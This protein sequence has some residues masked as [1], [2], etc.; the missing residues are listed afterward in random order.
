[1]VYV[2]MLCNIFI[3]NMCTCSMDIF[4]FLF[5]WCGQ[6]AAV[7]YCIYISNCYK[8][9]TEYHNII[10]I[11]F[12]LCYVCI[13]I[14]L[15]IINMML[16]MYCVIV[17]EL[18]RIEIILISFWYHRSRTSKCARSILENMSRIFTWQITSLDR[19]M[20]KALLLNSKKDTMILYY[21]SVFKNVCSI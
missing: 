11:M 12:I 15:Q 13:A 17:T 18:L 14:M 5:V 16:R 20:C 1:M 2:R 8:I 10:T 9:I 4:V 19:N 7:S 6:C 3:K 21:Y